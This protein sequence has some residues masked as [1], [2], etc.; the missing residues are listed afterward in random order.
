MP[1]NVLTEKTFCSPFRPSYWK[2]AALEVKNIRCLA[3]IAMLLAVSIVVR[4]YLQIPIPIAENLRIRFDFLPDALAAA[5][6]GP[7]LAVIY[8]FVGDTLAFLLNPSGAYFPGYTLSMMLVMLLFSLFFY[9]RK[10]SIWRVIV[11]KF[12][13]NAFINVL[14]GSV[15]SSMMFGKAYQVYFWSSLTKNSILFPLEVAMLLVVFIAMIPPMAKLHLI[16]QQKTIDVPLL[17]KLF[18]KEKPA[19]EEA[20]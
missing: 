20:K 11:S 10:I 1:K 4:A 8:G 19:E 13:Y 12:L 16:P 3:V 15:W 6:G 7:I 18:R 17:K 14:L 5:I 2:M 9:R